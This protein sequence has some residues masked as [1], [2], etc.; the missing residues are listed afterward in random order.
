[1][2]IRDRDLGTVLVSPQEDLPAPP[3]PRLLRR[4]QE[5]LDA[6]APPP[7]PFGRARD[8]IDASGPHSLH[9]LRLLNRLT[10]SSRNGGPPSP[11][12]CLPLMAAW[13][14][15]DSMAWPAEAWQGEIGRA[16]NGRL[17]RELRFSEALGGFETSLSPRL[18][19]P[20]LPHSCA[21]RARCVGQAIQRGYLCDEA[22][23]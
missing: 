3:S 10:W 1:M 11:D 20:P 19:S 16:L 18:A 14:L 12:I 6:S 2:C 8:W 5:L 22:H 7:R 15:H 9:A 21:A 4:T 13:V 23:R 17:A